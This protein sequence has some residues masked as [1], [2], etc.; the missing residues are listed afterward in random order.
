MAKLETLS[1]LSDPSYHSQETFHSFDPRLSE[2]APQGTM[3]SVG[4]GVANEQEFA[5]KSVGTRTQNSSRQVDGS[6]N[7][8]STREI[9]NRYS[10]EEKTYKS[11]KISNSIYINGDLRKSEKVKADLC[12]NVAAN[13]EK[14]MPP[15][16]QYREPSNPPKILPISGKLDQSNEPL[17]RPSAFKP[18]VPKNFHSMQNLCPPQ[19]NGITENRKTLNHTNSNSPSTVKSGL[20]KPSLN[21]TSNQAGGLSDSGRN[22]LTSLPTYGTGYSQHVGPM[23]ASTS[24]INRIGTAYADKNIVGYN[25]ISTSD[26]GRSSS[27]S[28]S[29]FS[30]LNHLNETM[31]F[32]SPSTDDIIQD[33]EDRLWEKEQ[34]VLQMR[35][36]LDKSEAAIYQVFEEK[37]KIWEREME[38]L[39]QNY[40]NKLQQVSKKAQRAQ[41]ALQLQIFKLQQ[42][43]KK[44]QDDIGQLLQQREELEKKFVAFKK[45]QAEFL[46]KIEETKWEV[47]QKAG[48]ISLLKQQLKDSQS[49]VSQKLNE[50][51]GLRTQLK[52]GKSF[53]REKEEQIL[54]LKD[55]Y[56]TKSVSL[57]I[58]EN[59]L[60]RKMGEVQ[61][62]REKLSQCE[63]EVSNLKQTLTNLGGPH[64]HF[65]TELTEKL[66]RDAL[67]C[68]SDEAKMKRQ[69]EESLSALKKEV[70]RL[71]AELKAERQQREQQ[72]VDFEEERHTWQ[73]EKEKVIKYQK[74]LQ[75]NY[76][77]MYQKNQI[78]EHKMNEMTSKITSP[79][80]TEEKKTWTPSRLERIESTEI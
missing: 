43:K 25:G 70:E 15:P 33:L 8:Y 4:S 17:V 34:E 67:A 59:D 61:M 18:V 1:L 72:V 54:T 40:A 74:Q 41:Q 47:C 44:L 7:N 48:E 13:N 42:E 31:P 79:P 80:H 68:E 58:C 45:E 10:G 23:S 73:E 51:V 63:L 65:N 5:M 30:R 66:A 39:R 71:Q 36:N 57:E 53:L 60:Q 26:S 49:D 52:E 29:S 38:D 12:G 2:P 50:I 9:S 76:V 22:S 28:T 27:K 64:S 16:P 19:N 24:H 37:Q 6:R 21:R 77:E 62:L 69:S 75:L 46:P 35:R 56:S 32:H 14:N 55:S 78:L 20:E 3:G 11:E